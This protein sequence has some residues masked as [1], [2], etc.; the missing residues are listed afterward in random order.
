VRGGVKLGGPE[1][2]HEVHVSAYFYSECRAK[3]LCVRVV[4][5]GIPRAYD[6]CLGCGR[7]LKNDNILGI[8][9]RYLRFLICPDED[10]DIEQDSHEIG[11]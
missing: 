2:V 8:T 4:E 6:L 3:R 9:H 11:R 5:V 7:R 10:V 1:P